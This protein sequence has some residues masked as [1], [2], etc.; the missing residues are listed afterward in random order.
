MP[1]GTVLAVIARVLLHSQPILS[2]CGAHVGDEGALPGG[3]RKGKTMSETVSYLRLAAGSG[4]TLADQMRPASRLAMP[5]SDAPSKLRSFSPSDGG[6]WRLHATCDGCMVLS[7]RSPE[8]MARRTVRRSV[9]TKPRRTELRS[10]TAI[11]ACGFTHR[12]SRAGHP[13]DPPA[14]VR[15]RA[16]GAGRHRLRRSPNLNHS[17]N[18]RTGLARR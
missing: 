17:H 4:T 18:R 13:L 16:D 9:R 11:G 8:A 2:G 15:G 3:E 1:S 10:Q 12:R 6:G 5:M 14:L 7:L